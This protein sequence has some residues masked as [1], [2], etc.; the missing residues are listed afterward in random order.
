MSVC[1]TITVESVDV[2]SSFLVYESSSHMVVII[3]DHR[4]KVKVTVAKKAQNSRFPQCKTS[5]GN[6]SDS[7]DNGAVKFACSMDFS[8]MAGRMV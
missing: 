7:I 4:V 3:H 5:V 2:E 1:N 6:N 8:A